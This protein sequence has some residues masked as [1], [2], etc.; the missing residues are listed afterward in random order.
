MSGY[1]AGSIEHNA[2]LLIAL[3]FFI[4]QYLISQEG[5]N[6]IFPPMVFV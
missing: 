1:T 5:L 6:D 2:W 4:P 3:N